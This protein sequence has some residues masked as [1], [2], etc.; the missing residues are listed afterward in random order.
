[1]HSA[2][3]ANSG[4]VQTLMP[5]LSCMHFLLLQ[6]LFSRHHSPSPQRAGHMGP[7][8]SVSVSFVSAL[9]IWSLH[10]R[11]WAELPPIDPVATHR[12]TTHGGLARKSLPSFGSPH[13]P[14]VQVPYPEPLGQNMPSSHLG[15]IALAP[16]SHVYPKGHGVHPVL[17]SGVVPPVSPLYVPG[18]HSAHVPAPPRS[19][20]RWRTVA[21]ITFAE[22]YRPATHGLQSLSLVAAS[23]GLALPGAHLVHVPLKWAG[24]SSCV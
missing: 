4:E 17:P 24:S 6:S 11:S 10:S 13:V 1:M 19:G 2:A 22:A 20:R 16:A 5:S 3:T 15:P 9:N 12:V 7:P 8:Q 14:F 23:F 18:W 21:P